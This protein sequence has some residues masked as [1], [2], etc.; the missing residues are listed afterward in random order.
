MAERFLA[1]PA[2][3]FYGDP[4][5]AAGAGMTYLGKTRGE[6]RVNF[7]LGISYGRADQVGRAGLADAVFS[8]GVVSSATIPFIDNEKAKLAAMILTGASLSA[9]G[10]EAFGFGSKFKA[11]ARSSILTLAIIPE[12]QIAEGT[13]GVDA[14]EGIWIPAAILVQPGEWTF[15]LPEGEDAFSPRNANFM[16]L[17]VE[18]DLDGSPNAIPESSRLGFVG[19]PEAVIGTVQWSLPAVP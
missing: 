11:I 1:S 2:H 16:G 6:I 8:S 10:K 13:N 4:A 18:E 9:G 5:Q 19:S 14:K 7:D 3:V 12:T 15:N 17:Y